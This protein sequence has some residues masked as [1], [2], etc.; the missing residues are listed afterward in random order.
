MYV[1]GFETIQFDVVVK[2]DCSL[3]L[4]DGL[5]VRGIKM[6]EKKLIKLLNNDLLKEYKDIKEML[7]T[8]GLKLHVTPSKY[9]DE[10]HVFYFTIS[11]DKNNVLILYDYE[12]SAIDDVSHFDLWTEFPF[13]FHELFDA[14]ELMVFVTKVLATRSKKKH[15][16]FTQV[17]LCGGISNQRCITAD[18]TDENGNKIGDC[19]F[20]IDSDNRGIDVRLYIGDLEVT[21]CSLYLSGVHKDVNV[22]IF[23]LHEVWSSN[24]YLPRNFEF[25]IDIRFEKHFDSLGVEHVR[26]ARKIIKNIANVY[27]MIKEN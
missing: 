2:A 11:D 16:N 21:T 7:S 24:D 25:D 18:V 6:N 9:E 10:P 22:E 4:T 14:A 17:T 20:T 13:A 15:I 19:S 26:K 12:F 5:V 8:Y 1:G 27:K 3:A 23:P